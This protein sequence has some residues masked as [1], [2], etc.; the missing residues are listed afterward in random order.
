VEP[1]LR[2]AP[3]GNTYGNLQGTICL[4]RCIGCAS[5]LSLST[6][7]RA[8]R[9]FSTKATILIS[10]PPL[11]FEHFW[12]S[13][14]IK[15]SRAK[16]ISQSHLLRLI[17]ALGRS[18]SFKCVDRCMRPTFFEPLVKYSAYLC[19]FGQLFVSPV[20]LARIKNA[21]VGGPKSTA[22]L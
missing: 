2:L 20:S 22:L 11:A 21:D 1:R 4:G 12:L 14:D 16:A 17:Q 10:A 3:D 5:N 15:F 13:V 9:A 8:P 6:S 18:L 7:G 19:L